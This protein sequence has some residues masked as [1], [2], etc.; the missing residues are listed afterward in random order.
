MVHSKSASVSDPST[1][2]QARLFMLS[3]PSVSVF[4]GIGCRSEACIV[5]VLLNN[6]EYS[7]QTQREIQRDTAGNFSLSAGSTARRNFGLLA[8]KRAEFSPEISICHGYR[9]FF[10]DKRSNHSNYSL[11]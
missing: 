4:P 1:S 5:R 10:K 3:D 11:P 7:T 9:F 8:G 6:D 2:S